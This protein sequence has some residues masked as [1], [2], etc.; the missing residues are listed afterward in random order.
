[1]REGYELA[2]LLQRST[3]AML[4]ISDS[5]N[6]IFINFPR[7]RAAHWYVQLMPRLAVVAGFEIG[8]GSAINTVLP[9]EA[10]RRL[11]TFRTGP[12]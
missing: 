7:Q 5:F 10:A 9:A 6:W 8:T 4:S 2:G 11:Q 1:M 3:R 12:P